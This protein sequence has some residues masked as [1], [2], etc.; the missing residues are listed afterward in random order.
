MPCAEA[1]P[2]GNLL[3]RSPDTVLGGASTMAAIW[4]TWEEVA[5]GGGRLPGW[6]GASGRAPPVKE[7]T[8]K[9]GEEA[10]TAGAVQRQQHWSP[11][12]SGEAGPAGHVE[13]VTSGH[14]EWLAQELTPEPELGRGQ[15]VLL[16]WAADRTLHRADCLRRAVFSGVFH[17][18]GSCGQTPE[19]HVCPV[20]VCGAEGAPEHWARFLSLFP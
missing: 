16:S 8:R 15:A 13:D 20:H 4:D 9:E 10:H 17:S 6:T 14:L 3:M 19:D 2:K 18:G 12:E 11:T 1:A 7:S 5:G